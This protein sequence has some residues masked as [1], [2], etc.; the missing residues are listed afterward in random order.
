MAKTFLYLTLF[1][2]AGLATAASAEPSYYPS[3]FFPVEHRSNLRSTQEESDDP[4]D[5]EYVAL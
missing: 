2:A 4:A 5:Y 1:C 3:Y